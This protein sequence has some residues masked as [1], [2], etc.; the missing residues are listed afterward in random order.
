MDI[1]TTI[2]LLSSH[3]LAWYKLF[4]EFKRKNDSKKTNKRNK[5]KNINS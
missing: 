3:G 5:D 1:I 4:M 2:L